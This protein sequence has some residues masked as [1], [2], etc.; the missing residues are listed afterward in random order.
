MDLYWSQICQL[1]GKFQLAR[2][3]KFQL[4]MLFLLRLLFSNMEPGGCFGHVGSH[5]PFANHTTEVGL[6]GLDV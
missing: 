3:K 2:A 4:V 1:A 5:I 6:A